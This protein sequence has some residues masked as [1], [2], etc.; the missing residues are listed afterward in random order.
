MSAEC[1]KEWITKSIIPFHIMTKFIEMIHTTIPLF[2]WSCYYWCH[3][4]LQSR[5]KGRERGIEVIVIPDI[6][7]LTI[8][9]TTLGKK[10]VSWP[11]SKIHLI[12]LKSDTIKLLVFEVLTRED[13]INILREV[14][15]TSNQCQ[16]IFT[17]VVHI[18]NLL[19]ERRAR[20]CHYP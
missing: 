6:H 18:I 7:D 16:Y 2:Y 13:K 4:D 5:L 20:S 11:W 17:I 14:V 8:Y 1:Q 15:V 12:K 10:F 3:C 9:D 19:E